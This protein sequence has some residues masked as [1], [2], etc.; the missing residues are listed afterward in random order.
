MSIE[1]RVWR[2]RLFIRDAISQ[3]NSDEDLMK[4]VLVAF[5]HRMH[6]IIENGGNHIEHLKKKDLASPDETTGARAEDDAIQLPNDHFVD[7]DVYPDG[8]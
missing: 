5:K 6:L 2:L 4:K 7:E 3:I 8:N 1:E